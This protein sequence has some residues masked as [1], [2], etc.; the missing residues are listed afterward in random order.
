MKKCIIISVLLMIMVT[1]A[2]AQSEMSIGGGFQF[3]LGI[4]TLDPPPGIK[5]ILHPL[6]GAFGFID[7]G[8]LEIDAALSYCPSKE[9]AFPVQGRASYL[10][11]SFALLGKYPMEMDGFTLFPLFGG[12]LRMTLA[13]S[14]PWGNKIDFDIE[15][16]L[17]LSLQL[18]GG[19][20]FPLSYELFIRAEALLS[21]DLVT[22]KAIRDDNYDKLI[23]RIGPT[24]KVGI[25]YRL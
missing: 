14:D 3:D 15:D 4:P 24:I 1:G 25:G 5:K 12:R 2:F 11:L 17:G 7:T 8:N 18:G 19:L 10:R 13:Q 6:Y 16:T 23:N 21:L 9:P 22:L 20:D